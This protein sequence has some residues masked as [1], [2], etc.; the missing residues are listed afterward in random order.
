[1]RK[2]LFMI[3]VAALFCG[4]NFNAISQTYLYYTA[5]KG[6]DGGAYG[7]YFILEDIKEN[8]F[9]HPQLVAIIYNNNFNAE[10]TEWSGNIEF[11]SHIDLENEMNATNW[12]YIF[13][14]SLD[15]SNFVISTFIETVTNLWV[16]HAHNALVDLLPDNF[17]FSLNNAIPIYGLG[18]EIWVLDSP[19][20]ITFLKGVSVSPFMELV[21]DTENLK[22]F[23][24][25]LQ[26]YDEPTYGMS[27]NFP[28][29]V[30][31]VESGD[32]IYVCYIRAEKSVNDFLRCNTYVSIKE[33]FIASNIAISPNPTTADFT[34]SF[35]LEKSCNM[36]I[37]L[38]DVLG[39][40]VLQIFNDFAN[41]GIFSKTVNTKNLAKGIY[42]LKILIDGN[43]TVEKIVVE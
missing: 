25:S 12:I 2:N 19:E 6:I 24:I 27:A 22:N 37:I 33:N 36:E 3:L 8:Y 30:S 17:V 41:E 1:M 35:E 21:T 9:E 32:S 4:Y 26:F 10:L 28:Y 23:T 43:I 29:W 14:D 31:I 38:C 34:V 16:Y 40:E 5:I 42:F 20:F 11:N 7:D 39:R 18:G 15:H 13:R